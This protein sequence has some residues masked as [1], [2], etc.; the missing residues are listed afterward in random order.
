MKP[1][2]DDQAGAGNHIG[3]IRNRTPLTGGRRAYEPRQ[4]T[5]TS[6]TF[7]TPSKGPAR[8]GGYAATL[9]LRS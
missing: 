8:L 1:A 5:G 7:S 9:A 3:H 2:A 6:L 4:V